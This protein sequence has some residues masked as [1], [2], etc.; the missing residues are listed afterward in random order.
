MP[1]EFHAHTL[2]VPAFAEAG[3]ELSGAATL[4][5]F[6]R[7]LAEAEGRGLDRPLGWSA[8]GEW[9][10]PH[11]VQPEAWLHLKADGVLP[12]TCQRCLG[13]V[14]VPVAIDRA[15]RFVA[16]EATAEAEDDASE[17]DLLVTSRA[18]DLPG[19]VEDEFLMAL[20]LVP[21]HETCP[22]P[23]R[24]SAVDPGFEVESPQENPFAVLAGLKGRTS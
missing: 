16:D 13:P 24:L 7:L 19:L 20:P 8:R 14:D 10:N 11:H 17:E 15:F 5:D 21:L 4:G 6:E 22:E 18:F 23:V 9:R 2:D 3:A 12:L 1:K